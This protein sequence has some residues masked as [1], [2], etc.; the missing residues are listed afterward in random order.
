MNHAIPNRMQSLPYQDIQP[1]GWLQRQLHIQ[2]QGI[3]GIL[4][5][6]WGSVGCY[7]DWIGG[8]ENSWERPPYWLD[9]L[10]P[11]AGLLQD[12]A[13]MAKAEKWMEW[14]LSSQRENG[15]FG[16]VY[17]T[18]EFD[19]TLFWPKYVVMKAMISYYE[20]KPK[21][22]ILTF[23]SRY[24]QFC[25]SQL[26]KFTTSGWN[27]AR[28]GDFVYTI[29][30]LHEKT[31]EAFLLELAE[32]MN[33]ATYNWSDYFQNFGFTRPTNYYYNFKTI[34]RES[35]RSSLYD[36]M[37]FHPTHIVNVVMAVKQ[38]LMRYRQTGNNDDLQAV[39][40]GLQELYRCHG[41]VAGIFSGDEH[42]SGLRP[43][44][45][46]ELCAV[47]EYLFSL[48]LLLEATGDAMFA[49]LIERVAYN[50]LP[51]TITE[52]FKAHQYDQQANQV[53]VSNAPREWYNNDP[54]SNLFGLEP[55]FGCCLANMHQGWPKML[56]NA[57]MQQDGGIRA[58]VYMPATVT[59]DN[60]GTLVTITEDTLY[61]ASGSIRFTFTT[62]QPTSFTFA[63][64]VPGW[65]K[66][67][68]V[69]LNG[70]PLDMPC[71][72][73]WLF[74]TR[75]FTGGD[76]IELNLEQEI[77]VCKG[78]YNNGATVER[79]PL[80]YGLKIQ[81]D[82]RKLPNG[83]PNYPDW[84]VHPASDWNFALDIS[85]PITLKENNP[86]Q[87]GPLFSHTHYPVVLQAYG[88]QLHNWVLEHNSA[89]E[90]PISPVQCAS[91]SKPIELVPY[92]ST[93][94]RISLFPWC[95]NANDKG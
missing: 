48:Q 6:I 85:K 68:H 64:R 47:V 57:F 45:G 67:H 7:S 86:P 71:E 17:R 53:L 14:S 84:E 89:G 94:L 82:W 78:W 61:P 22:E 26:D 19:E 88:K 75:S 29:F 5:E 81:E 52:D 63:M 54:D 49:D 87:N 13:A 23:M 25:L 11:L 43:T 95:G 33:N 2:M 15:D 76:V 65:C 91:E 37:A 41:Q 44:Q 31:G 59:W 60:N 74:L 20:C 24:M 16:P 92:G 27:E 51:A 28:G 35:T 58:C 38:P 32:K 69:T 73:N 77:T 56:K 83:L 40:N 10:V 39:Y 80:I 42:L 66:K 9:G 34:F 21:Q 70:E 12:P 36:I 30:W 1:G 62:P 72:N 18:A 93:A 4:D 50:A 55:N 90:Q 79:G 46:T 3:T 8:T